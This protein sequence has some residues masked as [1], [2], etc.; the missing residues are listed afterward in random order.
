MFHHQT[1]KS[2]ANDFLPLM[3]KA[4]KN[5]QTCNICVVDNGPDMNPA[6]Y[7][8][9]LYIERLWLDSVA[10]IVRFI[11]YTAGQSGYNVIEHTWSPLSNYLTSVTLPAVLPGEE[12]PPSK[13]TYLSKD[14]KAIK[15]KQMLDIACITFGRYCSNCS[16]DGHTVIPVTIPSNQTN[17]IYNV[18]GKVQSFIDA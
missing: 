14:E 1:L 15:E 12:K 11:S 7:K 17:L 4:V 6:S 2:H 13:Q 5:G 10:D 16:F 3:G 8:N 9:E 18:H